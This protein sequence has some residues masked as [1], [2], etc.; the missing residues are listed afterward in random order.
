MGTAGAIFNGT[1]KLI[2]A[3]LEFSDI[4]ILLSANY[5]KLVKDYQTPTVN[6]PKNASITPKIAIP[7]ALAI[8]GV[9]ILPETSVGA[10]IRAVAPPTEKGLK[11][12]TPTPMAIGIIIA[13][14][15]VPAARARTGVSE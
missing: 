10:P 3:F 9:I 6:R 7:I 5:Y 15:D 14:V 12:V 1:L 8:M 13:A 2:L 11:D 4:F